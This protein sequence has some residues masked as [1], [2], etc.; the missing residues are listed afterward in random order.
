MARKSVV[1]QDLELLI[2][3]AAAAISAPQPRIPID[4]ARYKTYFN[5]LKRCTAENIYGLAFAHA[6]ALE[7]VAAFAR[8]LEGIGCRCGARDG[9]HVDICP[10]Q[11]RKHPMFQA[12][13]ATATDDVEDAGD[14]GEAAEISADAGDGAP[15]APGAVRNL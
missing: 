10:V 1:P 7:N 11:L 4:K 9:Q 13:D 5:F 12:F 8:H 2:G 6:R 14:A 15:L 3:L